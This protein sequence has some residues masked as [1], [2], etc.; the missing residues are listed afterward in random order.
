MPY[1][2]HTTRKAEKDIRD[3]PETVFAR[4]DTRI[5][6][7]AE[8]P[9]PPDAVKIKGRTRLFR[10]RVGDYRILFEVDDEACEVTV[11]RVVHRREA[12]RDL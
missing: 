5:V 8:T 6:A 4:V 1:T 2:L 3:L 12:Y 9:H 7:L 11:A 10:I